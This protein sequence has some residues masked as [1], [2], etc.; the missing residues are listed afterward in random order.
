[1][2][3]DAQMRALVWL[4][5]S[6]MREQ[7]VPIPEPASGEVIIEVD[8]V[9]IC[10]SELSGYLGQNSLRRPPL[11]M[12]HEAAGCIVKM[13]DSATGSVTFA[14]GNTGQVGSRVTFNPLISC[15]TCNRC[16]AGL[17][18]LCYN[19][20]LIGAARP[21]AFARFVAVPAAQCWAVPD[22]LSD[23]AA[24]LVEPLACAVRA[25]ALS[26]IVPGQSLL[27]LG[28]GPIGLLCLTVARAQGIEN[29]L[30][31][32]LA[33]SRL[34]IAQRWGASAVLNARERD[35]VATAKAAAPEGIAAVIDAVGTNM[36]RAQAI[37]AVVPGGRVVFIGLHNEESPLATNYVIRQE[38]TIAGSFGYNDPDFASALM[39]L[40]EGIVQPTPDWLEERPLSDGPR[41]FEELVKGTA[42]ATKIMLR[43]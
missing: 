30:I 15:G 4:G 33:P 9:G 32:D 7:S 5:P 11:I 35:V 29:V 28:A 20:Q 18:N 19:R 14:D 16:R 40:R 38:I 10:G 13:H 27:I 6:D 24:A 37:Q 31:S 21:G 12:G 42:T 26:H 17:A 39:M 8:A 36:T 2:L 22:T 1:M 25:V 41:S 3:N 23:V 43:I 34:A